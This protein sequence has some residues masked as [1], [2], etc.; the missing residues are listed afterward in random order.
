V[1]LLVAARRPAKKWLTVV[2]RSAYLQ[3]EEKY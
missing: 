3:L 2:F 1:F